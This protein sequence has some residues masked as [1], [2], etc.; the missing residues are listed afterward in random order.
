MAM[1]HEQIDEQMVDFLYGE[2]PA[3]ARAAFEAHVAGCE[4]CRREVESL[5]QVRAVART[6]LDD[7]PPARVHDAILR[8]A[9]EAAAPAKEAKKEAR[10]VEPARASLWDWLRGKWAFPALATVGA[11][12]VFIL[13]SRLFL[14]P[15]T[16]RE[17]GRPAPVSEPAAST[18]V[19]ERRM[20]P[21]GAL[22]AVEPAAPAAPAVVPAPAEPPASDE[23]PARTAHVRRRLAAEA[24]TA[25]SDGARSAG[26]ALFGHGGAARP[27][28]ASLKDDPLDGVIG[29]G[30]GAR[31]KSSK[32]DDLL[33]GIGGPPRDKAPAAG[34]TG[35]AE[36][37]PPAAEKP[38]ANADFASGGGGKSKKKSI[39]AFEDLESNV[40][41]VRAKEEAAPVESRAEKGRAYAQP[42]PPAAAPAPS[43]RY[44]EPPPSKAAAAESDSYAAD[45][46]AELA[47]AAP[48][49]AAKPQ[50]RVSRGSG[51][52][53]AAA[54]P[55][56]VPA[57]APVAAS[58]AR[59]R[60]EEAESGSVAEEQSVHETLGQRA[61]RLF[62]QGRW[63]E[64]AIAYRDLLRQQPN[65]PD[66][67][68]W[69]RRLAAA[70][71]AVAT[72]RPPPP[73]SR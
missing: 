40:D 43:P 27:G 55:P 2:L 5:G 33:E 17:L 24:K 4:R 6:V 3:D 30:V 21:T 14:N 72:G 65:S 47:K 42:P 68:R 53:P 56:P 48:R 13:G 34:G 59:P 19:P 71:A 69:R 54:A 23:A 37:P 12:T 16:A 58:R 49:P 50:S 39:R 9:R 1:T 11:L 64:A 63:A 51:A 52:A 70:R 38:Q 28:A 45:D 46:S 67:E 22:R 35:Y 57:S 60:A 61:E 20:D 62:T 44:A 7:A 18:P 25:Q 15:N 31:E 8:A 73:S 26:S 36:P 29:S 10:K 66:A 32:R 41:S